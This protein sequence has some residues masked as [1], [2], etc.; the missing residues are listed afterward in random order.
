VHDVGRGHELYGVAVGLAHLAAVDAWQ[1]GGPLAD[2]RPRLVQHI[3]PIG[4]RELMG[5]V[6]GDLQMLRLIGTNRNLV[7]V[8]RKDVGR[9]Q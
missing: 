9:H 3:A 4:P 8:K 5:E 7:G 6:N 2:E 1:G